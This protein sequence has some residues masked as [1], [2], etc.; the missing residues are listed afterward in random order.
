M[1]SACLLPNAKVHLMGV[2]TFVNNNNYNL[3]WSISIHSA[4]FVASYKK[5]KLSKLDDRHNLRL[6]SVSSRR[7]LI[8]RLE[9]SVR[10]EWKTFEAIIGY[11]PTTTTTTTTINEP[12]F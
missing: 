2:L 12:A 7:Q 9:R 6:V 8:E 4:R 11:L 10:I 1:M 3:D 5:K